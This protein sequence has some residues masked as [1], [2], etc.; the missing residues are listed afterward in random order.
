MI[1][2]AMPMRQEAMLELM[3]NAPVMQTVIVEVIIGSVI[4]IHASTNQTAQITVFAMMSAEA[5]R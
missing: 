5:I 4:T 3:V 2:N 1:I